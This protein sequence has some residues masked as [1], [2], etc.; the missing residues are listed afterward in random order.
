[1]EQLLVKFCNFKY[2]CLDLLE[3]ARFAIFI[4][5]CG[6]LLKDLRKFI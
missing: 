6:P 5:N 3:I 1:M 4:D 2:N